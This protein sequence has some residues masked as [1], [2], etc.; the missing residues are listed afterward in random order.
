M[1][2][3]KPR[4]ERK[5]VFVRARLRTDRGWSDVTIGNV[6]SRGLMLQCTSPLRR[7]DFIE[8][9]YQHVCVIGRIVWVGGTRCGVRTQD[10]VD[11]AGLLS[12]GSAKR[13]KPGEDRRAVVRKVERPHRARAPADTAESSRRMARLF[14]WAVVAIGGGAAAAFVAGI[15]YSALSAP[16][17]RIGVALAGG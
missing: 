1:G 9:R 2:L 16:L 5:P 12:R 8:V 6:S 15:V 14:D 17:A 3:L 10:K 11:V 4:E 13:R 7:N